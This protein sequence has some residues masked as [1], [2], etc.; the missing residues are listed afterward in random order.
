MFLVSCSSIC[1]YVCLN[2]YF[3]MCNARS[4]N[5]FVATPVS[6]LVSFVLHFAPCFSLN[7]LDF[8]VTCLSLLL[9]LSVHQI[10]SKFLDIFLTF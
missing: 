9:A 5:L 7:S 8:L 3:R 2:I 6:F 10:H 4:W 1:W